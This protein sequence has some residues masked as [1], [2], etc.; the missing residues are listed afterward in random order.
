MTPNVGHSINIECEGQNGSLVEDKLAVPPIKPKGGA[1]AQWFS[2][3]WHA[4]GPGFNP[5]SCK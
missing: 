2:T 4:Q 5:Q 3:C 1:V